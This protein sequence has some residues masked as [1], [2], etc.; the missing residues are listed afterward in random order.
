MNENK[1]SRVIRNVK[2]EDS[3]EVVFCF[4]FGPLCTC[5]EGYQNIKVIKSN[6]IKNSC[7]IVEC[8]DA[9]LSEGVIDDTEPTFHI[10]NLDDT[11]EQIIKRCSDVITYDIKNE[12]VFQQIIDIILNFRE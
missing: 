5:G 9:C 12:H 8:Y 6:N 4:R 7:R 3:E 10:I 2:I 11:K 1:V